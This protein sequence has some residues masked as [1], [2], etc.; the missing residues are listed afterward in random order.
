MELTEIISAV[1]QELPERRFAHTQRVVETA[2]ELAEIFGENREKIKIA[3]YL[4]DYCKFWSADRLTEWIRKHQLPSELLDHNK[5]LW[6][7]PVGAEVAR[8]QFGVQEDDILDAIRYHTSG[9]PNMGLL[10]KIIFLAD[11]VEP[12]RQ[13]PGVER[14]R[15][16]VKQDLNEAMLYVLEHTIVFLIEKGQKVYPQTL[17]ARNA[18]LEENKTS[19]KKG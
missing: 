4:H 6:H 12:G 5:E 13:F 1:R 18:Y 3:G 15:E 16:L 2:L 14:A 8:S 17:Y 19:I 10:E 7:G 9:R 11:F